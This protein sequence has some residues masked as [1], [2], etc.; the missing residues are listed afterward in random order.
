MRFRG[1]SGIS[2]AC[3]KIFCTK[4]RHSSL[5]LNYRFPPWLLNYAIDTVLSISHIRGPQTSLSST[6]IIHIYSDIFVCARQGDVAGI[7]DLF[8]KGLA[9][10]FDAT[11]DYGYTAL[12]YV[13]DYRHLELIDFLLKTGARTD[14][15]DF[16][17]RSATDVACVKL[18]T[19]DLDPCHKESVQLMFSED[20]WLEQRQFTV[21]H[22]IVLK[23]AKTSL[24]LIEEL[25]VS[26]KEI[27]ATDSERRTPLSWAV[28]IGNQDAVFTLLT[29]GAD[30]NKPDKGGDTPLHYACKSQSFETVCLLLDAGA[31]STHR[32]KWG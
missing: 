23:L 10:P 30:I 25:R 32:N 14:I 19:S 1:V 18:C 13:I 15:P 2:P 8:K 11:S 22:K 26:T 5:K 21:L 27:N 3:N 20:S 9:S 29:F 16:N 17:N 6:R 4:S 31:N 24:S 12:H 28:E 7:K